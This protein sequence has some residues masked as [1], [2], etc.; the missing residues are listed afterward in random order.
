MRARDG[1]RSS[2]EPGPWSPV[3]EKKKRKESKGGGGGELGDS[4]T[5]DNPWLKPGTQTPWQESWCGMADAPGLYRT[6]KLPS[7]QHR[8]FPVSPSL[9]LYL[10]L[11]S[12]LSSNTGLYQG[13][14]PPFCE[15][16]KPLLCQLPCVNSNTGITHLYPVFGEQTLHDPPRA[17]TGQKPS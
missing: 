14:A 8:Y 2:V 17:S 1:G 7:A 13:T 16:S 4:D 3:D 15:E 9:P 6:G 11:S 10:S 5:S 12:P